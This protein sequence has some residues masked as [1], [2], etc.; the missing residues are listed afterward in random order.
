M[1][2]IDT[3]II[4]AGAIGLACAAALAEAGHDVLILEKESSIGTG[5]SSRNS[6]VIHAGIYYP[7]GS[8]KARTCTTGNQLLQDY[9]QKHNV[10]YRMVG[11]LIVAT[12]TDEEQTLASIEK[13]AM[14][15]DVHTLQWLSKVETLKLEPELKCR[16]SLISPATGIIDTHAFMLSLRGKAEEHGAMLA[17]NCPVISGSPTTDGITLQLGDQD[18]S[19]LTARN[20]VI[21][22]GLSSPEVS[23][24]LGLNN[25]PQE[26]LCKGHYFSVS[27]RTPFS[28]L[29]YPVP[30]PGGLG[31]HYT[32]DMA[33]RGRFGPD[34]EWVETENYDVPETKRE[35]FAAAIQRYW[36]NCRAENLEPSY[37]GIRPKICAPGQPDADFVMMDEAQHGVPGVISLL[38]IESPGITSSLALAQMVK[39]KIRQRS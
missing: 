27:G 28:R 11:K 20:V 33:G 37:A 14:A 2:R 9:A 29:V 25:I 6:E 23:R 30:V 15:N 34:V 8:L 10:P 16:S 5:V 19:T 36:P 4:G 3:V 21:A 1:H 24:R 13:K 12:S 35:A 31:V 7:Q 22:C 38:G 26:Y 39:E 32:L 17:L 18:S